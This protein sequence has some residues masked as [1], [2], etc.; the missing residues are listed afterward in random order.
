MAN[1]KTMMPARD[2]AR[3]IFI[4]PGVFSATKWPRTPQLKVPKA[5]IP[6]SKSSELQPSME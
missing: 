1:R 3:M 6:E 2:R 5:A 4:A